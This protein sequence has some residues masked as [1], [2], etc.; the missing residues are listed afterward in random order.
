MKYY[1]ACDKFFNSQSS[2]PHRPSMR[3]LI[4]YCAMNSI[5]LNNQIMVA[6]HNYNSIYHLIH[7]V[8]RWIE[9]PCQSNC[10]LFRQSRNLH[11]L[12]RIKSTLFV[13]WPYFSHQDLHFF[14][15]SLFLVNQLKILTFCFKPFFKRPRYTFIHKLKFLMHAIKNEKQIK[16]KG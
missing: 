4:G 16:I 13:E 7:K 8:N 11:I 15:A 6:A 1:V 9:S 2:S 10:I 12:S 5:A 14:V 3:M